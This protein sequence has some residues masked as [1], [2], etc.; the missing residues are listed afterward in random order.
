MDNMKIRLIFMGCILTVLGVI[1][2]VARSYSVAFVGIIA[3]GI[4]LASVGVIWKR[5][6]K[7]MSQVEKFKSQAAKRK[8]AVNRA[9]IILIFVLAP[10]KMNV[11]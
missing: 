1:L 4:V 8:P 11:I 10:L 9:T 7:Q 3:V 2:L 5:E 6:R